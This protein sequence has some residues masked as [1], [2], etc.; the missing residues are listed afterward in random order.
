MATGF[1]N[2]EIKSLIRSVCEH[3][4]QE[5]G[6]VKLLVESPHPNSLLVSR[7]L[8][9]GEHEQDDFDE[10]RSSLDSNSS[11]TE[12]EKRGRVVPDVIVYHPTIPLFLLS[13][14]CT[15]ASDSDDRG[16]VQCLIKMLSHM[17]H[18]DLHFGFWINPH[19]WRL[20]V[21]HK[22]EQERTISVLQEEGSLLV[23]SSC[24]AFN[25]FNVDSLLT[26]FQWIHKALVFECSSIASQD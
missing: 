15:K 25:T 12:S 4:I 3:V 21:V 22:N 1:E 26:L 11:P 19:K 23:R 24:N 17:H 16:I 7:V 20:M 18:Q 14:E 2:G 13:V 5:M 8:Q 9:V 6:S 10:E